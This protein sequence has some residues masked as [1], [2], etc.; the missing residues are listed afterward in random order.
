MFS[1]NAVKYFLNFSVF[2][3]LRMWLGLSIV[4]RSELGTLSLIILDDE[5]GVNLSFS[6]ITW[7]FFR[8]C[9]GP[10]NEFLY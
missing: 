5:S 7:E 9:T 1:K 10:D 2:L 4:L 8:D 3:R 6:P